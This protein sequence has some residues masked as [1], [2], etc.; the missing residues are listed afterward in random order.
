MF[1]RGCSDHRDQLF[2]LFEWGGV[3]LP[4]KLG[5]GV[6]LASSRNPHPTFDQNLRLSLPYL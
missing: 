1:L 6:R 4:E 2:C 5:G 3:V